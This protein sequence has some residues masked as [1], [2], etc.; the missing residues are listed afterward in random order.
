MTTFQKW[1]IAISLL[2]ITGL[3]YWFQIRPSL[4]IASCNQEARD[5]A[6]ESDAPD[7]K[8][9]YDLAYTLCTRSN[10]Y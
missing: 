6:R 4:V 10:G 1:L 9:I 7:T 3:F 2:V 5:K 8:K